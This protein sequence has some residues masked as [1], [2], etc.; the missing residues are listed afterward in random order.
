MILSLTN[1]L[2]DC[3]FAIIS[4][5]KVSMMM[6]E[7]IL[8]TFLETQNTRYFD[9]LYKR[10]SSKVYGKCISILKNEEQAEDAV[11]EIFMKILIN[12]SKFSGRSK[13]S[14]WVYSITY[15]FCID[16]VRRKKK[17]R[18]ILVDDMSNINDV[19]DDDVNDKFLL[20]MNIRRLEIVMDKI[21]VEEKA[22]LLMKYQDDM[23]I[24]DIGVI[25]SKSE[26]A[27]KMKIR[28]AKLKS[29][30]VYKELFKDT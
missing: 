23:S 16:I 21:N 24:R 17:T 11:Q 13:F 3:L 28:R 4:G 10:Y 29:R 1:K 26:S 27:V 9:V 6:D 8:Q 18:A 15:N 7:E 20:E 25:L 30:K 2:T 19:A 5:N 22:I 14:T 12:L